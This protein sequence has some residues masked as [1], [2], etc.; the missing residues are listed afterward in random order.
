LNAVAFIFRTEIAMSEAT[1]GG[2]PERGLLIGGKCR[3][4]FWQAR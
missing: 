3:R 2:V 1:N 4:E